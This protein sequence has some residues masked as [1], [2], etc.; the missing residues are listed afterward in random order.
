M[1]QDLPVAGPSAVAVSLVTGRPAGA[2][3]AEARRLWTSAL[4]VR[5]GR[6]ADPRLEKELLDTVDFH[7]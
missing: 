3:G 2:R 1:R 6:S 5:R 7:E 4:V